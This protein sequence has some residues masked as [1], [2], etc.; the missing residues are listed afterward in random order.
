MI[1]VSRLNSVYFVGIGGIG[2]SALAR[3]FKAKGAKVSGYDK[4]ATSLTK[5]LEA[6]GI[7]V[8][9]KE[10]VDVIPTATELVVYTPAVS[11]DNKELTYCKQRDFPLMKRSQVLGLITKDNYTIAVAGTHG[12]TTTSSIIAHFL[13]RQLL[14]PFFQQ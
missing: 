4:T 9:F 11:S 13:Y 3:W 12:K 2:M 1:E 6:E 5:E 8:H 7:P 14:L 10:D